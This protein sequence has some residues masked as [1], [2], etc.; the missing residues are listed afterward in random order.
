MSN[1]NQK[2]YDRAYK[3]PFQIWTDRRISKEVKQLFG[4][5]GHDRKVL[6]L[7][8]GKG[9]NS[10]YIASRGFKVTGVDF[11]PTA[12]MKA[13]ENA[14]DLINKPD[15]LVGDVTR[16]QLNN[17]HFDMALDI[18]CFHCL[19]ANDQSLY[20]REVGHHIK[21]GGSLLMWTMNSPPPG[22]RALSNPGII[23]ETFAPYFNLKHFEI[24]KRHWAPSRWYWLEK[25]E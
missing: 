5:S 25:N 18:G 23:E 9:Y 17:E 6:E 13:R 8:C 22:A 16:L 1:I 21:R 19:D 3:F 20:A 12:V 14:S 2:M 11:S 7:G 10:I 24:S 4:N 15:F